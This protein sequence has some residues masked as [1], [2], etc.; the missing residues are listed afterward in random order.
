MTTEIS[1]FSDLKIG[2]SYKLLSFHNG[3]FV[4]DL[5]RR[6][7]NTRDIRVR[8]NLGKLL[9]IKTY[10]RPYDPDVVHFFENEDGK[11]EEFEHNFGLKE[12]YLEYE[13]DTEELSRKRIQERVSELAQEI[14]GNDWALRPE[15]VVATQ[16][17]DI[18]H[19][20]K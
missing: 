13:P 17:I 7:V 4:T 19:F 14:Q 8:K 16:G 5:L 1:L 15:N 6:Q 12:A 3:V 18:S 20:Q 9:E 10:G 2:K 11:R